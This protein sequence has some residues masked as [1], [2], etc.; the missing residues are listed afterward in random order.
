MAETGQAGKQTRLSDDNENGMI[1]RVFYCFTGD[2][3]A[4]EYVT[5]DGE[6]HTLTGIVQT[7]I[8][9]TSCHRHREKMWF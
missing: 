3:G 6:E 1:T 7:G 8:F 2:V 9:K 4:C 5:G